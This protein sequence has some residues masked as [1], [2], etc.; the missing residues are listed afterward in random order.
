[1]FCDESA[2]AALAVVELIPPRCQSSKLATVKFAP[3]SRMRD[4]WACSY[5][6]GPVDEV[7]HPPEHMVLVLGRHDGIVRHAPVGRCVVV[8]D[9]QCEVVEIV[10]TL[11][12]THFGVTGMRIPS[13][14]SST[15]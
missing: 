3:A 6:K 13:T 12:N 14:L 15:L 9:R 10:V 7:P 2:A 4:G 5:T 8:L 11:W 1:M